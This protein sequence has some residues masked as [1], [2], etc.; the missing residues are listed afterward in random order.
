MIWVS[1]M[2]PQ[3]SVRDLYEIEDMY[4]VMGLIKRAE[5][6]QEERNKKE[7]QAST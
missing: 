3:F 6:I 1:K 2:I 7:N 5:R 4:M